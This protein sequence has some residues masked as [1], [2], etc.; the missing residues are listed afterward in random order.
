MIVETNNY[1]YW[2]EVS[3]YLEKWF[4]ENG[5]QMMPHA[6]ALPLLGN[7]SDI[8]EL[9]DDGYHY[10]RLLTD[11]ETITKC[12]FSFK[13]A[14]LMDKLNSKLVENGRGL[15]SYEEHRAYIDADEGRKQ[16]EA[17]YLEFNHLTPKVAWAIGFIDFLEEC[18]NYDNLNEL[19][20]HVYQAFMDAIETLRQ[21][22]SK[23]WLNAGEILKEYV[24]P[25]VSNAFDKN[26]SNNINIE[27]NGIKED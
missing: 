22:G 9:S 27:Q 16:D 26:I 4:Y 11:D 19:T 17:R 12:V 7:P 23:T 1:P 21:N 14:S 2:A 20:P 3:G 25:I 13:E 8:K 5:G 15:G 10:V 6:E 24:S 18:G